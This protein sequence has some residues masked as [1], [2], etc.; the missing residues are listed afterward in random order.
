MYA[1][2]LILLGCAGI[3]TA[4]ST[5]GIITGS[6][7]DAS[8][9]P[10]AGAKVSAFHLKNGAQRST[11]TGN[12]GHYILPAMPVGEYEVHARH[13]G[14]Q[15]VIRR[16]LLLTVGQ[17]AVIYFNL[18]V[19]ELH[20]EVTVVAKGPLTNSRSHELSYLVGAKN[21]EDLPLNGRN[22]LDLVLLQPGVQPFRHRDSGGSIVA[23]GLGTSINGQDPRSNVYLLDGTPQNN[24]TNGPASSGAGTSLGM[25]TIREF[26]VESNGYS[27]EFGRNFGGQINALTKS[28]SNRMHGSVFH[29]LRNDNLDARNFFDTTTAPPEFRRNQFGGT[30]GGPIKRDQSFFFVGYEGIR[31][32]LGRTIS[33]VVPDENARAGWVPDP[34]NP[35]QLLDIGINPAVQPYLNEFPQAN[36]PNLGGGLAAFNFNFSQEIHQDFFQWRTDHNLSEKES[37]FARYTVDEVAQRLPTD[38][39]QFPRSF[40]SRNQFLTVEYRRIFSPQLLSTFRTGFSRTRIGQDVE[41]NTTNEIEP[42]V[43]GRPS[44]GDIDIGGIPR[45]GPQVSADV[46]LTQNIFSFQDDVIFTRNRHNLKFGGLFE[47]YQ[48]NLFNPTFSRGIFAFANITG[49]LQNQPLRFIGLTPNSTV[50]RYWR[51]S[52]LGLYLQDDFRATK[53]LTLN[54][55]LR[56]EVSTVP[57]E[58]QGRDTTLLDLSDKEPTVGRIYNNPTEKNF[59]PRVGFAWDVFD[60]GTTVLRGGYGLFFNTNNQQNLI[61]TVVNPPSARRPVIGKPDFPHPSFDRA[62]DNS[63]RPIA[64]NI[65]SPYIQSWNLN[66]QRQFSTD[67]LLTVGYTG[68]RGIH[69]WR[70]TDANT[71]IPTQLPNGTYCFAVEESAKVNPCGPSG[72][73]GRRNPNFSTIELKKSDGNSWYNAFIAELRRRFSKGL[74]VQLSYTLSRSIDTTQAS[75]FFSDSITGT[76]SAMPEFP[77]LAY[78]KGLS[79]FHAKH[80]LVSNFIWEL[81]FF[82]QRTGSLAAIFR[83]WQAGGLL[84]FQSGNPLTAMVQRNRSGSLWS[85]T[86]GPGRGVDRPNLMPGFTH[87]SSVIGDPDQYFNPDAFSL[88]QAG[89]MGRLGRNVFIGPNL[90]T[91]DFSLAKNITLRSMGEDSKLQFR[92]EFFNLFNRTN[93]AAPAIVAF[94][95]VVDGETPLSSFGRIRSTVTSSRQIQ[96]GIRLSF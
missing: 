76:T 89:T 44:M 24:F 87:Q 2:L 41:V 70:N 17:T 43:L 30:L 27:A 42:F 78:N 6:V 67:V 51:F 15:T 10:I 88:Q 23:H 18:S 93:F 26:R 35:K 3:A 96:F 8:K 22:Y 25:D 14:F 82:H 59:A 29:Y 83:G 37:I 55:G 92:A 45:F 13:E 69:L 19:G 58:I 68:S 39:P 85:P 77:G 61:V 33:T 80:T 90:R 72:S 38:F 57:R 73:P 32:N 48:D 11:L 81:P 12:D 1:Q 9:A 84:I 47:R 94:A 60:D 53:R 86:V 36:A 5:T 34:Q 16:G 63:I 79:D 56:Y 65:K 50:D 31:E 91:V 95:G 46:K 4:Q 40:V 20:L 75:T 49:F 7:S 71:A 66:L 64:F 52:L 21:M 54:M 62:A 28:G 74:Q